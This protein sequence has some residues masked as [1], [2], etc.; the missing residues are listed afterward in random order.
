MP[1]VAEVLALGLEH[2]RAGRLDRAAQ[3]YRKILEFDAAQPDALHLLATA[4][5]QRGDN[6]AALGLVERAI[7]ADG[8][9]A[10][11][12]AT[13]GA[14]LETMGRLD[15]AIHAFARAGEL[16]PDSAEHRYRLGAALLAQGQV[17]R[18]AAELAAC[19]RLAPDLVE[20]RAQLGMAL[21][22]LGRADEARQAL[23]TARARLDHGRAA[24]RSL[25]P[26]LHYDLAKALERLGGLEEV[27]DLF[28][29]AL[30]FDPGMAEA[31]NDVGILLLLQGL[32]EEALAH[33]RCAIALRPDDPFLHSNLLYALSFVPGADPDAVFAE[34][35]IWE[36]RHARPCYRLIRPHAN[37][38]DPE[39]KLRIGYLSADLMS[40]PIT[41]NVEGLMRCHDRSRFAV[42]C[43]SDVIAGAADATTARLTGLVDHWRSTAGVPDQAVAEMIRSDGIDILVGLAG[44]TAFNRLVIFAYK[45]A[46][47]QVGYGVGTSGMTAMDYWLT[48]AVLHPPDTRE[49]CTETLW[50]LPNLVL[51]QP[52]VGAPEVAP[53]PFRQRGWIT[54]GSFNNPAKLTPELIALWARIL[55]SV[56]QARLRLK[57]MDWL[58]RPAIAGRIKARFAAHG[59]ETERLLLDGG[60]LARPDHLALVGASDIMLDSFP[61][62]GWTTTFEAMWMGVP[63]VTVA[64]DRFL[65]RVGASFLTAAGY[66]ELIA[67]DVEGY[68]EI[69]LALARDPDRLA[70]LR[71]Q[72]RPRLAASPL[73]DAEAYARAVEAAYRDMWRRWCAQPSSGR[74][75]VGR[76]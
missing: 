64:G 37:V 41:Y 6:V 66:P 36:D 11:Y 17:E 52:P 12:H 23:Q 69:A 50:R 67:R 70:R 33:Y 9:A 32:I 54:F 55:R 18:A 68:V 31:H 14:V 16:A 34:H 21:L 58:D 20:A 27:V 39:R 57:Y 38:R 43:Y 19:V 10:A 75:D 13:A 44:H 35:R 1:T 73:C 62:N 8:S 45:P 40:H 7:A 4:T 76:P 25:A 59:I 24:D 60:L 28:L 42:A 61:F 71:A 26:L 2:H 53:L 30:A 46:P 51:H 49:R 48:D 3:I 15:Q 65:G 22:R 74:P 47:V 72:L 56:P 29:R 63:V 5:H